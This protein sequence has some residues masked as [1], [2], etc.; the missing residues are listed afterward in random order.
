MYA[1]DTTKANVPVFFSAADAGFVS[2]YLGNALPTLPSWT[3]SGYQWAPAVW[4]RPDGTFVLYY[5]TADSVPSQS[6]IEAAHRGHVSDGLCLVAWSEDTRQCISAATADN[7]A[8][9]FVDHSTAPFICPVKEGGAI[10]PSIFVAGGV[11]YLL[12][13]SDGNGY[14][15]P[16]VIYSQQLTPDGLATAGPPHA[17]IGATQPWEGNLVE[18]PAMVQNGST[19]WLFYSANDWATANYAVGIARCASV[20]GPCTK[21]LDHPW[22][23]SANDQDGS[24]G[25][26]G[27]EFFSIGPFLCMVHHG[28]VRGQPVRP[29]SQ[30]RLYVRI[31]MFHDPG[32]L[33]ELVPRPLAAAL[34]DIW[35]V[36]N[37]PIPAGTPQQQYLTEMHRSA[38]ALARDSDERLLDVGGAVCADFARHVTS[39]QDLGGAAPSGTQ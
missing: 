35:V 7:P 24:L 23:S 9:P 19:Y 39:Q 28:F 22:M 14:G 13:K 38:S 2:S 15:L 10:D 16:T 6:C 33:P 3:E 20:T 21:P 8:G 34:A 1:T 30:R 4:A 27:E 31:I 17:L 5:T 32:G 26:G 25:P 12:W 29:D 36:S 37:E 11:P 18:G